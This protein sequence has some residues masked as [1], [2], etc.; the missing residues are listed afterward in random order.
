MSS[1]RVT[2]PRVDVGHELARE[3]RRT[4]LLT[5]LLCVAVFAC[6]YALGRH[7]RPS[8]APAEQVPGLSA[9]ATGASIPG[10]LTASPSLA[11]EAPVV[12]ARTPPAGRS[13]GGLGTTTPVK[14]STPDAIQPASSRTSAPAT[15]PAPKPVAPVR[16]P[17]PAAPVS[18]SGGTSEPSKSGSKGAGGSATPKS[19]GSTS[20]ENSG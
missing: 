14:T 7:E 20:F 18:P 12:V 13:T 1:M 10:A 16:A 9:A 15:I 2:R 4:L 3:R 8:A 19:G 11:I 6:F 17:A 5:A